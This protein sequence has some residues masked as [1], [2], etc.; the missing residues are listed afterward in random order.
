MYFLVFP[1]WAYLAVCRVA[2][3][4]TPTPHLHLAA[5]FGPAC[6]SQILYRASLTVALSCRD[7]YQ[8]QPSGYVLID[9]LEVQPLDSHLSSLLNPFVQVSRQHV[10]ECV[11]S[12]G[13]GAHFQHYPQQ[14]IPVTPPC[15]VILSTVSVVDTAVPAVHEQLQG[16]DSSHCSPC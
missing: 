16:L 3:G 10:Q 9:G 2:L 6:V 11:H 14:C 12:H 1:F 15:L 8:F 13:M 7:S 4:S 5:A